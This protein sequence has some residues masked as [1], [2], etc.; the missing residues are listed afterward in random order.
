MCKRI[1]PSLLLLALIIS[2]PCLHASSILIRSNVPGASLKLDRQERGITDENGRAILKDVSPGRHRLILS[3]DGYETYSEELQVKDG[4]TS[5]VQ[6]TLAVLDQIP[7]EIRLVSPEPTRG[8]S[9]TTGEKTIQI[10][11]LARDEGEVASVSVNGKNAVLTAPKPE[12]MALLPGKTVKFTAE[13]SLAQ[14]KNTVR[15][16]A[17]DQAGN[18]AALEQIFD[19]KE[20]DLL[21]SLNMGCHALLIGINEYDNCGK[22]RNPVTDIETLDKEL[23]ENYGFQTKILLNPDKEEIL[24]TIRSY[25][26][27]QFSE[28]DELLI[29]LSGHGHFDEPTKT[30]YFVPADGRKPADDPNFSTYIGY[31][32]L[33]NVITYIPCKHILTVIDACFAGT[34]FSEIA[35][36]GEDSFY[37][38]IPREEF[39]L[40]KMSYKT[41]QLFTSGGREYVPDGR[42]GSHSPFMRKFLEGL[43]NFGGEDGILTVEELKTNYMDYVD[44][45]P[46]LL[47]FLGNEPGGSFLFIA[48]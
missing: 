31:P 37:K 19:Y 16:E 21:A 12:E 41:R 4:L 25:Y 8:I 26:N 47:E 20:K 17:L 24:S 46:F 13:A 10:T 18:R 35:L 38:E 6:A 27:R 39:I 2:V 48:R 14:G 5:I 44:P 36:K 23:K 40:R 7:P 15:I 42:P 1:M 43:R 29:M 3:M 28:N 11:G 34:F 45:Q 33:Q 9:I 32:I 22:L 30:G